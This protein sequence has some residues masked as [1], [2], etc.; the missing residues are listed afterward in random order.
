MSSS[1]WT[2]AAVASEARPCEGGAWRLVEDQHVA[3]TMKLA[4]TPAEQDL[5]ESLLETAKPPR[6]PGTAALHYLLITPFRYAPP[7]GGSRFRGPADPGVFYGAESVRT[8]AAELGYWRWRFLCDA[9]A[10]DHLGPARHTAFRVEVATT[11]VDL[12]V[13]PFDLDAAAWQHPRDYAPTQAFGRVAREAG[14]GGIRYR[15]VRDTTPAWCLAL[16]TPDAFAAPAPDPAM[17]S[18][19][20]LATR[21][22]VRWRRDGESLAFDAA[23]WQ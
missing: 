17:Q 3:A 5:L 19:W 22:R 9:P 18:W 20:L 6:P 4:D 8:A 12:R 13:A 15:S 10:L 16:L 2:P 11:V 7:P 21:E 23:A 1:T 14:L